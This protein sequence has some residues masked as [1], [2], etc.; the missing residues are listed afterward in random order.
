MAKPVTKTD[1]EWSQECRYI[2]DT[3]DK[4]GKVKEM[5]YDLPTF[6]RYCEMQRDAAKREGRED[7]ALY[8]Q[9]CLDDMYLL[10]FVAEEQRKAGR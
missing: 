6:I 9:E 7:S 2:S 8:I 10:A 5:N 1:L 3:A 4:Q